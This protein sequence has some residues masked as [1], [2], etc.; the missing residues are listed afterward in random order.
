L[1][2]KVPTRYSH[3]LTA[4]SKVDEM[5]NSYPWKIVSLVTKA[6]LQEII[7]Q[8][9]QKKKPFW[10]G[11]FGLLFLLSGSL[12]WIFLKYRQKEQQQQE[13]I[14]QINASL[15]T[16]VDERTIQL[17]EINK[18]LST[19]LETTSQGFIMVDGEFWVIEINP[20]MLTML[21]RSYQEVIGR[22]WLDLVGDENLDFL[23]EKIALRKRGLSEE[24]DIKIP[25]PDGSACSCH[26]ISTPLLN[27]NGKYEG[28][29]ALVTDIGERL[30]FEQNLVKAKA[31][32][33][34]N[35]AA[36][37][38]FLSSM[39]HG[40]R[41]PMNSILGFAQLLAADESLGS[42]EKDFVEKI[43]ISG[44]HL[45][46]LI[47]DILDLTRIEA[48]VVE[49]NISNVDFCST[50]QVFM[51]IIQSHAEACN[52]EISAREPEIHYQVKVDPLR[53]Q[54]IILNL[55]NNAI[56]YNRVGGRVE[57]FCDKINQHW[58]RLNVVD[59]GPGIA[60]DQ[61]SFL[62]EPFNRLG[63]ETS[64][65]QGSGLGLVI[66]RN[67]AELMGCHLGLLE[68]D[69]LGCHFYIDMPLVNECNRSCRQASGS[70]T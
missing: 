4:G 23:H 2:R 7:A 27:K 37:T 12:L 55:L 67:L 61:R 5:H 58:L 52:V 39:S 20:A 29:F 9:L 45:K 33:E 69:G 30:E 32:A 25:R 31:D 8:K 6:R 28:S 47:N 54:Q 51:D 64:S 60:P 65:I 21:G 40:F 18:K 14:I 16:R 3:H 70:K 42:K 46:E 63:V 35:S 62:F 10:L 41:T 50:M 22:S 59:N 1:S 48:G 56:K 36:K 24:Y 34:K 68:K 53:L 49:I 66:S 44:D 38:L 57:V 15:E 26:F 17:N 11:L 19:I 43:L 13:R